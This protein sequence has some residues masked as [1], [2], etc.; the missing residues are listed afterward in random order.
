MAIDRRP[1]MEQPGVG[2][3]D[4]AIFDLIASFNEAL[5]RV[6]VNEVGE[7]MAESLLNAIIG[8]Q[9]NIP[10]PCRLVGEG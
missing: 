2:L 1:Q 9:N 5:W 6:Q 3:K 10:S 4:F 8:G 7:I